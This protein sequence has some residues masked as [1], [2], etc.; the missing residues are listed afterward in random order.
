MFVCQPKVAFRWIPGN[1]LFT[2]PTRSHPHT[3]TPEEVRHLHIKQRNNRSSEWY[4]GRLAEFEFGRWWA[5]LHK[6]SIR[7]ARNFGSFR[8][9][10]KL[11]L[12][13]SKK[14]RPRWM[15]WMKI[16]TGNLCIYWLTFQILLELFGSMLSRLSMWNV[17][18][19]KLKN[20]TDRSSTSHV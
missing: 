13:L 17:W 6:S 5:I 4:N 14:K 2:R 9:V 8:Y 12:I 18:K 16:N 7:T 3:S 19:T 1:V 20:G 15:I 10:L 11:L